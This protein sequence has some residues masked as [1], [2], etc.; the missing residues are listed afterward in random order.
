M[1]KHQI[2]DR[3]AYR[4][5][6][7]KLHPEYWL[8]YRRLHPEEARRIVRLRQKKLAEWLNEYKAAKGCRVCGE[9]DPRC[10]DLHHRSPRLGATY[11]VGMLRITGSWSK[12]QSEVQKCDVLCSNCHRRLH[13]SVRRRQ[14]RKDKPGTFC[15]ILATA[16]CK[17]LVVRLRPRRDTSVKRFRG[18]VVCAAKQVLSEAGAADVTLE[19]LVTKVVR[20]LPVRF[21]NK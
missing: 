7:Y 21:R 19:S 9:R 20:A 2:F 13:S 14:K 17:V 10:L 11:C 16:L 8:D 18:R 4:K 6:F 15:Q 1:K 3:A 12:L 5:A